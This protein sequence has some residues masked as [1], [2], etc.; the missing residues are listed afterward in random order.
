M[1]P[2]VHREQLIDQWRET[3]AMFLDLPINVIG[4]IGGGKTNPQSDRT[5]GQQDLSL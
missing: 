3:L 2:L 1:K 4:Q 5:A